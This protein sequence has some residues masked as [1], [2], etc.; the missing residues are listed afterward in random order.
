ME[1]V[2]SKGNRTR[3]C[4]G[5]VWCGANTLM[6]ALLMGGVGAGEVHGQTTGCRKRVFWSSTSLGRVQ[7][8]HVVLTFPASPG[9]VDKRVNY[10][11]LFVLVMQRRVSPAVFWKDFSEILI[12]ILV[13]GDIF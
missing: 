4:T 1:S 9:A 5:V 7:S 10:S 12:K 11:H 2:G 13:Q 6:S 8:E 3:H